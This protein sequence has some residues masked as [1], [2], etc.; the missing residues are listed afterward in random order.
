MDKTKTLINDFQSEN[1]RIE[2]NMLK[3][4]ESLKNHD[5]EITILAN[6]IKEMLINQIGDLKL[7]L[8]GSSEEIKV[9]LDHLL[10]ILVLTED[11]DLLYW[12]VK[13]MILSSH[14]YGNQDELAR[15]ATLF[16]SLGTFISN[17]FGT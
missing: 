7:K 13:H 14:V 11:E 9:S 12:N 1:L 5:E 17:K 2:K 16:Q 4:I 15:D 3:I 6:D 10:E 8:R